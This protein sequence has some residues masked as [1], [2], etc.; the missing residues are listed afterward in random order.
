MGGVMPG[1]ERGRRVEGGGEF[2]WGVEKEKEI[3]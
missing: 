2:P 1:I 3:K